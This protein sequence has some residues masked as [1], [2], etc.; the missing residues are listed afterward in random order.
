MFTSPPNAPTSTV[1]P[2]SSV[3]RSGSGAGPR[4][5]TRVNPDNGDTP[6]SPLPVTVKEI[7]FGRHGDRWNSPN[8]TAVKV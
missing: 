6:A 5:S 4:A 1:A 3:R 7:E 8:G 2:S